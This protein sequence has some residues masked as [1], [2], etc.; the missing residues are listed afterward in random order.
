[1]LTLLTELLTG[2][3]GLGTINESTVSIPV[4]NSAVISNIAWDAKSE[5][6]VVGMVN[7]SSYTYP[8][9]SIGTVEE[10]ARA[11]SKGLFYSTHIKVSGGVTPKSPHGLSNL[12]VRTGLRPLK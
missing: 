2:M 3:V 8:N 6:L 5:T 4:S 10:F 11:P 7:G 12:A 1:M 9:T